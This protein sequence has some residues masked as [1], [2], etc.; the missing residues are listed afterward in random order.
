MSQG[1]TGARLNL[2]E[3]FGEF[4]PTTNN[5]C[6]PT[7]ATALCQGRPY[8]D[9]FSVGGEREIVKTWP[10]GV[11]HRKVHPEPLGSG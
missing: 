1:G 3:Y 9:E 4:E 8:S 10:Y 2:G 5:C 7:T 11:L 6:R